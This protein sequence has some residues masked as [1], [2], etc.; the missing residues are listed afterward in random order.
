MIIPHFKSK[1]IDE[2]DVL[3]KVSKYRNKSTALQ[4]IAVDGEP[5]ATLTVALDYEVEL[6]DGFVLIKDYSEN[7]GVLAE[8]VRNGIVEDT[9][10]RVSSGYVSI[11]IC[12]LLVTP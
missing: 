6:L 3:L 7:E 8:L 11:P 10:N 9:G 4:L 5:V 1:Y 2:R 12:K